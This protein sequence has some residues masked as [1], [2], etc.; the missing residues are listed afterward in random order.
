MKTSDFNYHLPKELIAQSPAIPRD[1]SRLLSFSTKKG[2]IDDFIFSDIINLLN[3]NDV[4]VRNVSKVFPARLLLNY[5]NREI[6]IFVLKILSDFEVKA[7]VRPGKIFKEDVSL[8]FDDFF[9]N[10]DKV[11]SDGSRKIS[12]RFKVDSQKIVKYLEKYGQ[13]PVP[14]YIDSSKSD[15]DQYQTVYAKERG[16]VAAPTAGLHFTKKLEQELI[17][18][19][20][21]FVDVVLH[22]GRGTFLPVKTEKIEEHKMHSEYFEIDEKNLN[23]LNKFY[24]EN[25]RLICVGT[26]SVRVLESSFSAQLNKFNKSFGE[27]DIFI[28]PG[29]YKWKVVDALITNFHLPKSTLLM[30]V[31]SF[32]ESKEVDNPLKCLMDIYQYAINEKYRFYSFGD[33]CFFY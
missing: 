17:A 33:A 20:V 9:I 18:R 32:L 31:S 19:G 14:P 10:V 11:Y 29:K 1:S 6:E 26:T 7:L 15:P 12:F 24:S 4:I 16:S 23:L 21:E 8:E 3:E 25:K 22:V 13:M 28:Y 30:L 2:K 5:K 27:T